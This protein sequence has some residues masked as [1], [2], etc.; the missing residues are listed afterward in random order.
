MG[1]VI[2]RVSQHLFMYDLYDLYVVST[3]VS[4]LCSVEYG[5]S[6]CICESMCLYKYVCTSMSVR[7]C[8]YKY[9]C[10]DGVDILHLA[11]AHRDLRNLRMINQA[12][13]EQP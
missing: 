5:Y 6:R 7:V 13:W 3:V 9:V 2:G 1:H 10:T 11:R 8:L 12:F 4:M